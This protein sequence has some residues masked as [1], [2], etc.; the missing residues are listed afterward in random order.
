MGTGP[1][2]HFTGFIFRAEKYPVPSVHASAGPA[3]KMTINFQFQVTRHPNIALPDL[4]M[5]IGWGYFS[6]V[7]HLRLCCIVENNTHGI[8]FPMLYFTHSMAH[9]DP[10]IS[11]RSL[12]RTKAGGKDEQI[13]RP[14]L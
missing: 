14:R 1:V 10:V 5:Q 3:T 4:F 11:L 12:H 2:T 9:T 6:M 13:T 8:P 7:D